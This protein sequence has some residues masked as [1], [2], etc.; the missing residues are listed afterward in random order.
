[1]VIVLEKMALWDLLVEGE[2]VLLLV[3]HHLRHT[4]LV[5]VLV[6]HVQNVMDA[7][8]NLSPIRMLHLQHW[9]GCS[10]TTILEEA[11][12]NIATRYRTT[13]IIHAQSVGALGR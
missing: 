9:D 1:M 12:A 10:H 13:T 8:S 5:T 6:R 4:T 11:I 7:D 2:A 3:H